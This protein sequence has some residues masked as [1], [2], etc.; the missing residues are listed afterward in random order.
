MIRNK[1]EAIKRV[2]ELAAA[3][4]TPTY[5]PLL[6]RAFDSDGTELTGNLYRLIGT[7]GLGLKEAKDL[8]EEIME[9]G[10]RDWL[11]AQL[12]LKTGG[13]PR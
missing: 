7:G 4:P 10:V 6:N 12:D 11:A 13:V 8:I 3:P 9:L 2:R 5:A 1:I